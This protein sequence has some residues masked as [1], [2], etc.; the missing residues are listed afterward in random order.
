M[1]KSPAGGTITLPGVRLGTGTGK[2]FFE[3]RWGPQAVSAKQPSP[4]PEGMI[5]VNPNNEN[6]RVVRK[7]SLIHI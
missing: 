7:L 5:Q 2:V 6:T 4:P 3:V 1:A